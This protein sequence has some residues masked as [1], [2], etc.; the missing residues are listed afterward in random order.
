[1]TNSSYP[2]PA[3]GRP[4][5]ENRGLGLAKPARD[6]RD[7][8]AQPLVGRALLITAVGLYG[9]LSYLTRQRTKEFGIRMALGSS[10]QGILSLVFQ[11]VMILVGAGGAV[12]IAA[13]VGAGRA[14][15]AQ[16]F[17]VAG[18]DPVVLVAAPAVLA[19]VALLAAAWPSM[20]AAAV[21][22]SE[23]LRHE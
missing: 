20:K 16:L 11:E 7:V 15:A 8:A 14:I 1:M 12:G 22:P 10:R 13:A 5:R 3:R 18:L 6:R 17:G 2:C 19:V 9:V 4:Q 23:A 21:H